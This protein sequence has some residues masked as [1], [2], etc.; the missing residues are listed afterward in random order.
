[1]VGIRE[2]QTPCG[3]VEA[4]PDAEDPESQMRKTGEPHVPYA[5]HKGGN[6]ELTWS[7]KTH[8]HMSAL[9]KA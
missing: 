7:E 2:Q 3:V 9:L 8:K 5:R 1:M 4:S 6:K